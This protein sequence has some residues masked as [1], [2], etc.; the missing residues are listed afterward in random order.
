MKTIGRVENADRCDN[1]YIVEMSQDEHRRLAELSAAL[2][3][4]NRRQLSTQQVCTIDADMSEALGTVCL[5][6]N[7]LGAIGRLE[8]CVKMLRDRLLLK[9]DVAPFDPNQVCEVTTKK[10][11]W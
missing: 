1:G 9:S 3:G 6:A 11:E 2:G 8:E 4:P 10:G 5:L 7:S